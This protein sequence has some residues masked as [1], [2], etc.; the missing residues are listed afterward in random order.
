[1]DEVCCGFCEK[2]LRKVKSVLKKGKVICRLTEVG[3]SS[4]PYTE[5]FWKV[6]KNFANFAT[7]IPLIQS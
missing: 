5:K 6:K 2:K 3:S 7:N 4:S 1:M